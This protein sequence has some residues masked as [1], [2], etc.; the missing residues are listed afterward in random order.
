MAR[1]YEE[2]VGPLV[3]RLVSALEAGQAAGG[4]KRGQQSAAVVVERVGARAETR[5]GIDCVCELRVE[6]HPQ[7]IAELRRLVGIWSAWESQRR[8]NV[9]SERGDH[10]AAAIRLR[11]ELAQGE[12]PYFSTTW[13]AT[14]RSP[15]R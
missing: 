14:S 12:K 15:A 13:R 10:A 6:D 8:A 11:A 9:F 3:E 7:P 5:E 1:A 2:T 4:D